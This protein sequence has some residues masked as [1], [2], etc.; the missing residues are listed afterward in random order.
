[1]FREVSCYKLFRTHL[2]EIEQV[3]TDDFR[4]GPRDRKRRHPRTVSETCHNTELLYRPFIL[5]SAK[6]D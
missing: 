3:G 5:K 6:M 2:P 1:M 4:D